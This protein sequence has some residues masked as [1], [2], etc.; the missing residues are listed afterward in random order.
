MPSSSILTKALLAAMLLVAGMIVGNYIMFRQISP[1][2]R[3]DTY[4]YEAAQKPREVNSLQVNAGQVQTGKSP[5]PN[6]PKGAAGAQETIRL[7]FSAHLQEDVLKVNTQV[8]VFLVKE[9]GVA[10]SAR[11]ML[12]T[13]PHADGSARVVSTGSKHGEN[14]K[15]AALRAL[16]ELAAVN[17]VP[18]LDFITPVGTAS[19]GHAVYVA[20]IRQERLHLKGRRQPVGGNWA[21]FKDVK[22]S[23]ELQEAA[24]SPC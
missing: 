18:D 7:S 17:P 14:G 13:I 16:A 9:V 20:Y 2:A 8:S 4:V 1:E 11:V 15:T 22:L 24:V 10:P 12:F 5:P 21:V 23:D 19:E 3:G 6:S